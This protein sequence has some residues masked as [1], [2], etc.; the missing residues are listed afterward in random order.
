MQKNT[1]GMAVARLKSPMLEEFSC[2]LFKLIQ[3]QP[4]HSQRE[5]AT[6]MGISLGKTNDCIKGLME[7]GWLKARLPGPN[8][9]TH[10]RNPDKKKAKQQVHHYRH[11]RAGL[12]WA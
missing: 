3:Q 12:R 10:E 1:H 6:E 4:N 7:E 5:L 8:P 11:R 2:K 9:A